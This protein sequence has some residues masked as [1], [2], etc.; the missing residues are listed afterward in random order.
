M[1]TVSLNLPCCTRSTAPLFLANFPKPGEKAKVPAWKDIDSRIRRALPLVAPPR[2]RDPVLLSETGARM[3][4]VTL[5]YLG[6]KQP[7]EGIA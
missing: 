4:M 6:G 5:K 2:S 7:A 1:L 3:V